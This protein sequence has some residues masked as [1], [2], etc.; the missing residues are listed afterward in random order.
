M[1][2]VRPATAATAPGAGALR[3]SERASLARPSVI[4]GI[5]SRAK[6]LAAT[7]RDIVL[8]GAGEPD[9]PT[10]RHILEATSDAMMHGMTRYTASNGITELRGAVA[11]AMRRDLQLAYTPEQVIVTTGA[12]MALYELFQA[13]C[14]PGDEVILLGPYWTSYAEIVVLAG[15]RPVIVPTRADDDFLPDPDLVR[16][17]ITGRTRVLLLNSPGNPT[18]AVYDRQTLEA[19]ARV[20]EDTDALVVSDDIY[21]KILFDGRTF[22]NIAQLS[23]EWQART[24]VVNGVSKAYSMTGFRIG[25]A[26]G[27]RDVIAAMGRVQDQ[28]T[29]GPTAF[30]QAGALAALMGP[31]ACVSEM[32]AAFAERRDVIVDALNAIPGVRCPSPAGA[33]YAFPSIAPYLG[34][35]WEGVTIDSS[36]KLAELLLDRVG[37]AL[38]PGEPFGAPEHLRLSFATSVEEIKRGVER[39]RS[40]FAAIV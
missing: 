9:F 6:A 1:S 25:W 24:V 12:K 26:A 11:A 38:V 37:V 27:P 33:F 7:G 18:G 17:A 3:L 2:H 21:E 29:S 31:Q 30:A 28:S 5:N 13:V 4:F 15:A 36:T 19:L 39:M 35:R 16:R 14:D 10:P 8:L 40:G 22:S 34:R 20:V 32:A 23:P